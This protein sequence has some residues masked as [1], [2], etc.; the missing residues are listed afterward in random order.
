MDTQNKAFGFRFCIHGI[1]RSFFLCRSI[2]RKNPTGSSLRKLFLVEQKAWDGVGMG[3]FI[4]EWWRRLC[5]CFDLEKSSTMV[6]ADGCSLIQKALV[7]RFHSH[8]EIPSLA[9]FVDDFRLNAKNVNRKIFTFPT[10]DD[11]DC[12]SRRGGGGRM[13]RS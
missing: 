6:S 12:D 10:N 1:A 9:E 7:T 11:C 8:R 4:K 2:P 3:S 5:N 13:G